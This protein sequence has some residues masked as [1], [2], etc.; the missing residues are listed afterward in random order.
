MSIPRTE[1]V[2][3]TTAL[4]EFVRQYASR[5]ELLN[6]D[7]QL[8]VSDTQA[9]ILMLLLDS[10]A[11]LSNSQL[12]TL[13]ELTRPAITKAVK[14]LL[15]Q[16]Y[17][18][19]TPAQHDGRVMEYQLTASGQTVAQEHRQRHEATINQLAAV[20]DKYTE[21]DLQLIQQFINELATRAWETN[22]PQ[23][24]KGYHHD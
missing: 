21:P 24:R 3:L 20:C 5:S 14:E 12:A 17:L 7:G 6:D 13:M 22:A 1:I 4:N 15:K 10:D 11:P 18:T 23:Q 8:A 19:A 16:G 2:N 9:H